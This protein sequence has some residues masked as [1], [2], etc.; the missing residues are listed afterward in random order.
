MADRSELR[1]DVALEQ[2]CAAMPVRSVRSAHARGLFFD[3]GIAG[4]TVSSF[5]GEEL[6]LIHPR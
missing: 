2:G 4:S 5:F 1:A 3:H 6:M